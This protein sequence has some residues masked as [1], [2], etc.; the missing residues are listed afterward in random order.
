MFYS[1]L[2]IIFYFR[3]I[4]HNQCFPCPV[5]SL[6]CRDPKHFFSVA[7]RFNRE[8][9]FD[10]YEPFIDV[11]IKAHA[12]TSHA[13]NLLSVLLIIFLIKLLLLLSQMK[14]QS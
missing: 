13:G 3:E 10:A 5:A 8:L 11:D 2:L 14:F 6:R 1:I 9:N 12:V 4:A 7:R